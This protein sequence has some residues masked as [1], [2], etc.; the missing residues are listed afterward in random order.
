MRSPDCWVGRS[1]GQGLST[2]LWQRG[3]TMARRRKRRLLSAI[4]REC[5][6]SPAAHRRFGRSHRFGKSHQHRLALWRERARVVSSDNSCEGLR[7]PHRR[8]AA[9]GRGAA[10]IAWRS[11]AKSRLASNYGSKRVAE[12]SSTP[13]QLPRTVGGS[14]ISGNLGYLPFPVRESAVLAKS[15][16]KHA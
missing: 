16:T 4:C 11:V 10:P 3:H 5:L 15:K 8:S 6:T 1:I 12:P 14:S 7:S 9:P 13:N 2:R